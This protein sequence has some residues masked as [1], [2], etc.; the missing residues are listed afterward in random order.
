MPG[1]IA[2]LRGEHRNIAK[3]L[4]VLEHEMELAA[5]A[6]NPDW[7]I[8]NGIAN[9]FCDYPDRCHHPKE[10]AV[11]RQLQERFPQE[12]RS[13][14][15]LL[16]EHQEVRLRAQRFRGH[17]QSI[18]LE[19]VLPR[20]KLIESARAFIHAERRHM[21]KEEEIFFPAAERLLKDEDW[22]RIE[23]Q[24]RNERDPLFEECVEHE[25]E[26]LRD[27]LLAWE[28]KRKAG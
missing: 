16:K 24:L 5:G 13:I 15:D 3:L 25:Y 23:M 19:D 21:L 4:D 8:L 27:Q 20:E 18:F 22:T 6:S 10:D 9:Y 11:F 28:C 1:T 26:S 2:T 17:I 12:A 14:G 7:D